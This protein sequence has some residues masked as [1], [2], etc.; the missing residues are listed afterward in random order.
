VAKKPTAMQVVAGALAD[1]SGRWLMQKRPAHKHHG[2][3]WEF[4][5]G[6]IEQ[7]ET[8][9]NALARELLEELKVVALPERMQG[10]ATAS[11]PAVDGNAAIV[12]SL[13]K[14]PSWQGVPSP[15]EGAEIGWFEREAIGGLPVPPLDAILA[16]ALPEPG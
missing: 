11:T 3:L 10:L 16:R 5:G 8:P 2:G 14:V 9:Q 4:P 12:I 1:P 15:E 6:K 7:G 13:Y